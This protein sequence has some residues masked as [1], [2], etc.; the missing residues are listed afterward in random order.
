MICS[1]MSQ[2]KLEI[3]KDQLTFEI[4]NLSKKYKNIT[5]RDK[6]KLIKSIKL[7]SIRKRR[8]IV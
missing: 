5:K 7:P 3:I 4:D 1:Q 2:D 8:F 6:N